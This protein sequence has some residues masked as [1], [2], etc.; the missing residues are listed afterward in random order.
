MNLAS[1]NI[2]VSYRLTN[3]FF[4]NRIKLLFFIFHF[5]CLPVVVMCVNI[6][7]QLAY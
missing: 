6:E 3:T 2:R 5:S 1:I 7:C 4:V